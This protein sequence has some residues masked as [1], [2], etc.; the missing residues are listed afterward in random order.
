[1]GNTEFINLKTRKTEKAIIGILSVILIPLAIALTKNILRVL[2]PIPQN[3]LIVSGLRRSSVL[4]LFFNSVQYTFS[5]EES[6]KIISIL[7]KNLGEEPEWSPNGDWIVSSVEESTGNGFSE[8]KIYIMRA[9]GNKRTLVPIPH[10]GS[11]PT[12][13]PDGKQIAYY[14]RWSGGIY[15]AN[16]ECLL[17]GES[18]APESQFIIKVSPSYEVPSS[19]DWSPD[20]MQILYSDTTTNGVTILNIDGQ[21]PPIFIYE[22]K[23][24]SSWSPDGTK[25]VGVC[26]YRSVANICTI[27]RDGTNLVRLTSHTTDTNIHYPSWSPDGQKVAYISTFS[28][29]SMTGSCWDGCGYPT[30]IFI[31]NTNGSGTTHVPFENDFVIEW[32]TWY[33]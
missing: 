19:P 22:I 7:P 4:P 24:Q 5:L 9:D 29:E 1:M 6:Q 26:Y 17:R 3:S 32:F 16:I 13:S 10:G 14:A 30:T 31:M 8:S 33:P 11:Q 18:C 28:D 25:I 15:T 2:I 20:G 27:N 23:G 21:D 12:W